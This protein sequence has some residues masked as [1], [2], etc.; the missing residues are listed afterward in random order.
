MDRNKSVGLES[1]GATT[2]IRK[3]R[4]ASAAFS[5]GDTRSYGTEVK[6]IGMKMLLH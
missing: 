1:Y 6:L 4:Y 3:A 5:S 2:S